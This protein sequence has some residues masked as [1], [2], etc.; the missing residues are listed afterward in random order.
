M[1]VDL[2]LLE[3]EPGVCRLLRPITRT[4]RSWLMPKPTWERLTDFL[5]AEVDLTAAVKAMD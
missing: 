2:G 1:E 4:G 5:V 3:E